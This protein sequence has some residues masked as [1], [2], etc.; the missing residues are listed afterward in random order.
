MNTG[1]D[2]VK[3]ASIKIAHKAGEF[4][5]NKITDTVTKLN[6]HKTIKPDENLRNAEEIIISLKIEMKYYDKCDEKNNK[7]IR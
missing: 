5:G 1:L 2:A 4:L 6:N 7:I 3:T